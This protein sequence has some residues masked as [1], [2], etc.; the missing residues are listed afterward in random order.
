MVLNNYNDDYN[1]VN[2]TYIN[3]FN[4]CKPSDSLLPA[5]S[6]VA[7]QFYPSFWNVAAD[8]GHLVDVD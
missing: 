3:S 1:I 7:T 5:L 4:I 6:S 8:V 2:S